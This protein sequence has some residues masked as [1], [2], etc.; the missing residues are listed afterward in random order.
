MFQA[1]IALFSITSTAILSQHRGDK[2]LW[3]GNALLMVNAALC[4]IS[5][6]Q[7][8]DQQGMAMGSLIRLGILAPVVLS[9]K[10]KPPPLLASDDP[11]VVDALTD[12]EA[13]EAVMDAIESEQ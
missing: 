4:L 11:M 13:L 10:P 5:E 7:H 12:D 6:L 8:Q 9:L 3:L 1:A 2:A